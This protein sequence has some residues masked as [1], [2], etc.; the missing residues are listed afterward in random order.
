MRHCLYV[1]IFGIT[2]TN[3]MLSAQPPPAAE[4]P[5]VVA[6][7]APA[8]GTTGQVSTQSDVEMAVQSVPGTHS[9]R[10]EDLSLPVRDNIDNV[11]KCYQKAVKAQPTLEGTLSLR[12][13]APA[14]QV[15]PTF[16]TVGGTVKDQ[17][18]IDCV[19]KAF[20]KVRVP[21]FENPSAMILTIT[22]HNSSAKGTEVT[23]T[24]R[25]A[26]A[27]AAVVP[28]GH[29]GFKG[30]DGTLGKE[31][32]F[33]LLPQGQVDKNSLALASS[34]VKERIGG[35]LDCRRKAAKFG[36]MQ[37]EAEAY[38]KFKAGSVGSAKLVS[39]TLK[40][41]KATPCIQSV[42]KDIH[43]HKASPEVTGEYTLKIHF[44]EE[45]P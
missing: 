14:K 13:D 6:T 22:F 16:S 37:G 20:K 34:I 26:L 45:T 18:L 36:T 8:V 29:G 32:V 2:Y 30:E 42:L 38:M 39:N 4:P 21:K 24:R 17:P 12:L 11:K 23:E 28:D 44:R 5:T 1:A 19:L 41:P 31:V 7:D 25:Q 15:R 9:T 35:L 43:T 33:E 40:G 27:A 10:F 3:S